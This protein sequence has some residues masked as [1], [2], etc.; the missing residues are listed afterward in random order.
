MNDTLEHLE[1]ACKAQHDS[2]DLIW[3][4]QDNNKLKEL[5]AEVTCRI[6][7]A[8][9][10]ERKRI[11]REWNRR[12]PIKAFYYDKICPKYT[13]YWHSG[14]WHW[15]FHT[16]RP[17][18]EGYTTYTCKCGSTIKNFRNQNPT[19]WQERIQYLIHLLPY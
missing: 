14:G 6:L 3:K 16:W 11:R 15:C 1:K 13:S 10:E 9:S 19:Y 8:E 4:E 2:F 5:H 7:D 12:H 17:K 18:G